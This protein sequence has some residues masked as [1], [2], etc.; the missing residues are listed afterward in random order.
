M[1]L[2]D[3]IDLGSLLVGILG[4]VGG[5]AS[6]SVANT[7]NQKQVVKSGNAFQAGDSITITIGE[8]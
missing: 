4:Y 3:L 6:C 5:W 7:V 2:S 1:H 8:K